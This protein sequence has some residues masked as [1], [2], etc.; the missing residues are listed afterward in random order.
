MK[1]N[2]KLEESLIGYKFVKSKIKK[3]RKRKN[4]KYFNFNKSKW[5]NKKFLL[6]RY[7]K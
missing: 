4:I 7:R 1:F 2:I 6:S 5:I 3:K